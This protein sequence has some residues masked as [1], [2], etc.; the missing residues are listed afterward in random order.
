MVRLELASAAPE[1]W[2][3]AC[4]LAL[5]E[6]RPDAVN[7]GAARLRDLLQSG[8]FE[9]AGLILAKQGG[10][11]VGAIA[12]QL[13]PGDSG[14]L[15]PPFGLDEFI[16][17]ALVEAAREYF[18][19]AGTALAHCLLPTGET[20][21]ATPLI[22]NGFRHITQIQH[23]LRRDSP[24]PEVGLTVAFE[25]FTETIEPV[26]AE[27]LLR[28][29]IDTLDLPETTLDRPASQQLA[30]YRD[31]QPD[32]PRWW[33]VR[34]ASWWPIGVVMLSELGAQE[35]WEIAYA[36]LIPEARG[37]GLGRALV[38]HGIAEATRAGISDLGLSVDSRNFKAIRVYRDLLFRIYE[39][40]DL[41]LLR[42]DA[43]N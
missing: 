19:N 13:L 33:L 27:I 35:A 17:T 30:G 22:A 14:V 21:Q 8:R 37:L 38:R 15:L 24:L 41:Y 9:P 12:A 32:P 28:T 2:S 5:G 6:L 42:P 39:L 31:G 36:G 7:T 40:Q 11:P 16:R 23:M 20:A 10:T 1:E 43:K 26:F 29:Y 34:N 3:M 18:R 25:P 4:R